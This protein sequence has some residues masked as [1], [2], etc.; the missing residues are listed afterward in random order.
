[1]ARKLPIG[2]LKNHR[3]H[4]VQ[5]SLAVITAGNKGEFIPIDAVN[6]ATISASNSTQVREGCTIKAIYVEFWVTGD[7]V[8]QGSGVAMIEIVKSG[9]ASAT[10]AEMASLDTYENKNNVLEIHQGLFNREDGVAMPIFRGWITIPKGK[11]RF[12]LGDRLVIGFLAQSD[13]VNLCGMEIYKEY[14]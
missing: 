13:G 4:I 6:V 1:M 10:A 8:V 3:K 2:I 11:Q 14:Y 5:H 7:D 12:A 9:G